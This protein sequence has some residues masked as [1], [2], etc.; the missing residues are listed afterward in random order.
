MAEHPN[1]TIVRELYGAF[2]RGDI[3][4]I[5]GYLAD[6]AVWHAAGRN[7]LVGDYHGREAVVGL[8]TAMAIYAEGSYRVEVRDVVGNERRAVG[9]HRST[10]KRADGASLDVDD[11]LIFDFV[12]GKVAEVWASPYDQY[13][14]DAFYGPIVPTGLTAPARA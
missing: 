11:V 7:W 14:E 9:L 6:N 12:D 1:V 13:E 10:A 5:R 2:S 4:T 8:L 3:E